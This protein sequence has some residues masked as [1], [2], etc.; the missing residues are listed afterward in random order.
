MS[1]LQKQNPATGLLQRD[2]IFAN[3][4]CPPSR[5]INPWNLWEIFGSVF[6]WSTIRAVCSFPWKVPIAYLWLW[7]YMGTYKMSLPKLVLSYGHSSQH[8]T[9]FIHIHLCVRN[10]ADPLLP[11]HYA[12]VAPR[13]DSRCVICYRIVACT[14]GSAGPVWWVMGMECVSNINMQNNVL[15]S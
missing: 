15:F 2:W 8:E 9:F 13:L 4:T 5:A 11:N 10:V 14:S 7:P 3:T 6:L 12:G 1:K